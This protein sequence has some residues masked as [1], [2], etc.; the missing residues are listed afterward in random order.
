MSSVTKLSAV[1]LA[2][3]PPSGSCHNGGYYQ[4]RKIVHTKNAKLAEKH[5]EGSKVTVKF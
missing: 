1:I 3:T 4:R 5:N 2:N